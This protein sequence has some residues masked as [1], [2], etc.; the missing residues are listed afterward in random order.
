MDQALGWIGWVD[1]RD[2]KLVGIIL[3]QLH[4]GASRPAWSS[5]A[6]V[7]GWAGHADTLAK[8]YSR[9]ITRIATKLDKVGNG[10]FARLEPVKP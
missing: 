9:A 2:R 1:A 3:G 10:C 7:L 4:R 8:R 5:A 6:A